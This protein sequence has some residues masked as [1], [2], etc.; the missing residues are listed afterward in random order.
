MN[1]DGE[2]ILIVDDDETTLDL[3]QLHLERAGYGVLRAANAGRALLLFAEHCPRIIISDWL[4]PGI[5][6]LE[7]CSRIR[8]TEYNRL[9]YFVM[10]TIQSEK[11]RLMEAFDVG[12]DDFLS[13]P[14]HEGELLA[15]VRAGCRLATV[16]DQLSERN[17]TLA[18]NNAE[19]SSLTDRL[20]KAASTDELTQLPNRRQA[21]TRLH[22]MWVYARRTE[23]PLSCAMIDVDHFKNVNDQYGHLK[24]DEVLQKLSQVLITSLR[25]SD[26]VYRIGG[27][28]FLLL[29]P[30]EGVEHALVCAER[31]RGAMEAAV[32][33][34]PGR[35]HAVT[36]SV[37]VA[38]RNAEMS[39]P[40]DL[41][42][43]ADAALYRA[44]EAGRNTV[45]GPDGSPAS[46]VA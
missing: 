41:L 11:D 40:D 26:T 18:R 30:R 19:L 5:D 20:R 14:F 29:F 34:D 44:K 6:G 1:Q 13:K 27:E 24:G 42:N 22:E 36:V 25:A 43:C 15:R 39:T 12:V 2:Q 7:L 28:E 21:M 17:Q 33:A 3:L 9:I 35:T 31:C 46:A 45:V 8:D 4:M 23:T 10:L 37:G 38:E 16:C 32:F